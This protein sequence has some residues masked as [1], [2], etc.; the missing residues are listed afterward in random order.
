LIIRDPKSNP[1]D[2]PAR[3]ADIGG[4]T[5]VMH[6]NL[7]DPAAGARPLRACGRRSE[8]KDKQSERERPSPVRATCD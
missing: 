8:Q 6:C 5:D 3:D 2:L 1:Y 4:E 7:A